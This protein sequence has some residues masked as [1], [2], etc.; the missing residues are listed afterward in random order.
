[1]TT[2]GLAVRQAAWVL[3]GAGLG[4][5][6]PAGDEPP[7]ELARAIETRVRDALEQASLEAPT[8]V[9]FAAARCTERGKFTAVCF[10]RGGGPSA[11]AKIALHDEAQ[12]LLAREA[13]N[14]ER[15]RRHVP[16]PLEAP[17]V[18]AHGDGVLLF[19][20]ERWRPRPH[21][22]RMPAEV[23]R[24]F[25]EFF[26]SPVSQ[27][28]SLRGPAHGDAVPWNLLRTRT[29]WLL[30]GWENALEAAPPFHDVFYYLVHSFATLGRPRGE[31]V[32]AGLAGEGWIGAAIRAYAEGARVPV[33][34]AAPLLA[35]YL[36]SSIDPHRSVPDAP[37]GIRGSNLAARRQF[38]AEVR[39]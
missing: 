14:L 29:G 24:A 23:A 34:W 18:L 17:T 15:L 4:R 31:E 38:L 13:A 22:L 28:D 25:G 33:D 35:R 10:G 36:E 9:V 8:D 30:V 27:D 19:A 1:V 11:I 16:A 2:K 3:A 26:R 21:P 20:L 37:V 12:A 39:R 32:V 7:A 6:L 5:L